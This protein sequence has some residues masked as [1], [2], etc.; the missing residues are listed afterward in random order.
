M[1]NDN[2]FLENLLEKEMLLTAKAIQ[3]ESLGIHTRS[4]TELLKKARDEAYYIASSAA[5]FASMPLFLNLLSEWEE[6]QRPITFGKRMVHFDLRSDAENFKMEILEKWGESNYTLTY[7]FSENTHEFK[8]RIWSRNF[9][10]TKFTD[11]R[12]IE[13][14]KIVRKRY[15]S[16]KNPLDKHINIRLIPDFFKQ[17]GIYQNDS[18]I[19]FLN[20]IDDAGY[21]EILKP[22][23]IKDNC[24][25]GENTI[26]MIKNASKNVKIKLLSSQFEKGKIR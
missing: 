24:N 17:I 19:K 11:E 23:L 5:L 26:A 10:I 12:F 2:K 20:S 15:L 7:N 25:L 13:N 18:K 16:K 3:K 1:K 6:V 22:S 8:L 14:K 9:L 21:L 4:P